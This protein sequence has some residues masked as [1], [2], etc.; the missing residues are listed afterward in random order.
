MLAS[1]LRLTVNATWV[2]TQIAAGVEMKADGTDSQ[3]W[4][5]VDTFVELRTVGRMRKQW[6]MKSSAGYCWKKVITLFI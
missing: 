2:I 3:N 6:S 4:N 1:A 5:R